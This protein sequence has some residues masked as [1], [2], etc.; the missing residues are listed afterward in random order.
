MDL[1]RILDLEPTDGGFVGHNLEKGPGGAVVFG[2]QLLAQ[3]IVAAARTLPD[4]EVLS[5]QTVFARGA[6]PTRPLDITVE[7]M[8]NGRSFGSVAVSIGQD[9]K[10]CTRSLALLQVPDPD[11]V[12]HQSAPP[13][14]LAAD[15]LPERGEISWWDVRYDPDIDIDDPD[16]VGPATFD[17]WSRFPDAPTDPITA[18]ALLG[19]AS[20]AFLLATAMRPHRG[21]APP[22]AHVAVDTTVV[23]QTLSF[24][25]PFDASQWLLLAHES[26]YAGRG[27]SFGRANAFT[28][29]GRLVASYVQDSMLRAFPEGRSPT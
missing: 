14:A 21:I 1:L 9:G 24:H 18:K 15:A 13:P 7:T 25:E 16:A 22:L 10:V 6:R 29:D 28:D 19:Y 4:K 5:L 26:P 12:R 3:T 17:V 27:R 8:S 11:L 20:D 2:G 23:T